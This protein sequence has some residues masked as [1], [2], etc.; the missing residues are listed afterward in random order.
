MGFFSDE[1]L[2]NLRINKMTLHVVSKSREEFVA[3]PELDLSGVDHLDF[4]LARLVDA[5][6]DS[7]HEFKAGSDA[8]AT[9]EKIASGSVR[10]ET[11]AQ[12]LTRRFDNVHPQTATAGAFFVFELIVEDP[13]V[14]LY[15]M[16]KYDYRQAVELYE[17]QGRN[18]LRQIVQAFVQEK[19]AIQKSAIVRTR[20]G[21]V[22]EALSARDRMGRAPDLTDYFEAFLDV[23]RERN[24]AQLSEDLRG[25]LR[26]VVE[27]LRDHLPN[28]DVPAALRA[29]KEALQGREEVDEAAVR[30]AM[31][32]AAGRPHEEEVRAAVERAVAR[33][34][35]A[36][37]LNGVAFKPDASVLRTA[38]RRR[39]RTA[40]GVIVEFP[41]DQENK[42]VRRQFLPDG[43]ATITVQ[44]EEKLVE[45][46]TL[47]DRSRV[48]A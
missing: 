35:K 21:V 33:Q 7:V 25:A 4:F 17:K 40:E 28:R 38:A 43:G 3:Q 6:L 47:P 9:I 45:D 24:N 2:V 16:M 8:K 10:F 19:G 48:S 32:V 36:K 18:A 29:V 5:A 1:E 13:T 41:G 31:L 14:R 22:E 30:E 23:K 11:G 42:T 12:E 37:K 46:G 15:G 34:L 27:G 39:I 44:T 20:D 26:S